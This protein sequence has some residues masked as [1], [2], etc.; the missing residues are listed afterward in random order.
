MAEGFLEITGITYPESAIEGD[1]VEFTIHTQNIGA[2][3]NFK[4][5][6][7]GDLTDVIEVSLG[8]GL[9]YDPTF[10]FTMPNHNV[11]ITVNAYHLEVPTGFVK[12]RTTDL[13]YG[14]GSAIAFTDTCGNELTAY[15]LEMSGLRDATCE[16]R[17]DVLH[18]ALLENLPGT[19]GSGGDGN[20]KLFQDATDPNEIWVCEN[21]SDY[22]GVSYHRRYDLGDSDASKVSTSSNSE[23]PDYEIS[24]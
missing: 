4:I 22:P 20:P 24:C 16:E 11:N 10:Q 2:D 18:P 9:T 1:L 23:N 6:L 14:S 3:D 21:R 19:L 8:A 15:G 17:T 12:F 7:I 13:S 5:E